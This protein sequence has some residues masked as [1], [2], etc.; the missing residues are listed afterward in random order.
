MLRVAGNAHVWSPSGVCVVGGDDGPQQHRLRQSVCQLVVCLFYQR[1]PLSL[2]G[3]LLHAF[4]PIR[5]RRLFFLLLLSSSFQ[6]ALLLRGKLFC[7]TFLVLAF[8]SPHSIVSTLLQIESQQKC[9]CVC[10]CVCHRVFI[11]AQPLF[12]FIH[13]ILFL[14][15]VTPTDAN[16]PSALLL[17]PPLLSAY[18]VLRV[19][20]ACAT[21]CPATHNTLRFRQPTSRSMEPCE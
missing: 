18:T 14:W 10:V 17:F 8:V 21:H 1:Q 20:S 3:A 6:H 11:L 2:P 4:K 9:V 7:F 15:C 12:P 16:T 19:T 5:R 13:R